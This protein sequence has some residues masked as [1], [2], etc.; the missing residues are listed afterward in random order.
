MKSKIVISVFALALLTACNAKLMELT[1]SDAD[2]A[3]TKFKGITLASLN[4]GKVNYQQNC[5]ECHPLKRPSAKSEQ[6]WNKVVPEMVIKLKKKMGK[7]VI[8][9][10]KHESLLQYLVTMCNAPKK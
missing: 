2:R 9:A 6:K 5:D 10:K 7:E 3:T 1:Q 8:D 4:E